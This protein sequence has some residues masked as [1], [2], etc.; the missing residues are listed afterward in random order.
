M[1]TILRTKLGTRFGLL[2]AA[3][4]VLSSFL[5]ASCDLGSPS[6]P[7]SDEESGASGKVAFRLAPE[8]CVKLDSTSDSLRVLVKSADGRIEA[9][10][11]VALQ[12]TGANVEFPS[13]SP[14]Q[15]KL[16]EVFAFESDGSIRWYGATTV[17]VRAGQ[18][19]YAKVVLRKA[20]GS[21]HVEI[22]LEE[23]WNDT[24]YLPPQPY[25][26]TMHVSELPA[27]SNTLPFLHLQAFRV[28]GQIYAK[29][30]VASRCSRIRISAHVDP[31]MIDIWPAPAA[32]VQLAATEDP[33]S[34]D[35]PVGWEKPVY[36]VGSFGRTASQVTAAGRVGSIELPAPPTVY[37][38]TREVIVALGAYA[39]NDVILTSAHSGDLHKIFLPRDTTIPPIEPPSPDDSSSITHCWF[40][41]TGGYQCVF[42]PGDSVPGLCKPAGNGNWFCPSPL[43][44]DK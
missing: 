30:M 43:A 25:P 34:C 31:I 3:P 24:V 36:P 26:D 5:F 13:I 15:S 28:G 8:A 33:W 23:I 7:G 4:L 17:D 35:D 14:G 9:D 38:S 19:S 40:D 41:S 29:T 6:V 11:S 42:A 37:V 21:I 12:P 20:S 32:F 16:V 44:Y 22:V 39:Y 27:P 1:R 10:R 18:T 2:L